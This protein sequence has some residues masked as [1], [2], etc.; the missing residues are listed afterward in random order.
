[1]PRFDADDFAEKRLVRALVCYFWPL[2][3]ETERAPQGRNLKKKHTV[4]AGTIQKESKFMISNLR[5]PAT[6]SDLIN[7]IYKP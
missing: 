6:L 4:Q 5:N 3:F 2:L 1:M 7:L